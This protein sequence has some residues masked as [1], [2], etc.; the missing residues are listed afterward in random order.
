MAKGIIR[1]YN[2]KI[3][4]DFNI[5]TTD[6]VKTFLSEFESGN[7]DVGRYKYKEQLKAEVLFE[8]EDDNELAIKYSYYKYPELSRVTYSDDCRLLSTSYKF[9][10]GVKGAVDYMI[11]K[12]PEAKYTFEITSSEDIINV[13]LLENGKLI[14]RYDFKKGKCKEPFLRGIV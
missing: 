2:S 8:T 13:F 9:V 14:E 5:I 6:D 11:E 1:I 12:F 10:Q 7:Y 3:N 4:K